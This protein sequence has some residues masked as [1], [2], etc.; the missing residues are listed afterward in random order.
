MKERGDYVIFIESRASRKIDHINAIES[1][2]RPSVHKVLYG[3]RSL[4]I[5]G[6]S[7]QAKKSFLLSNNVHMDQI[8]KL[9]SYRGHYTGNVPPAT[10]FLWLEREL[11]SAGPRSP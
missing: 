10:R 11:V 3:G 4:G 1:Q 9:F 8:G 7:Q 6:V 5:G 2:I